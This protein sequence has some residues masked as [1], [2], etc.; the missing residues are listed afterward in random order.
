MS[1]MSGFAK[2]NPLNPLS[3]LHSGTFKDKLNDAMAK[4][5]KK[6]YKKAIEKFKKE[7]FKYVTAHGEHMAEKSVEFEI[8]GGKVNTQ[9][10]GHGVSRMTPI[11]Y[12]ADLPAIKEKFE[13]EGFTLEWAYDRSRLNGKLIFRW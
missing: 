10:C 2:M 3:P 5:K 1:D 13:G 4:G 7:L 11:C 12:V 8:K 9:Y 6:D